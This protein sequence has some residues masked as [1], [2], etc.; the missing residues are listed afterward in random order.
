MFTGLQSGA[1]VAA[2]R[3]DGIGKPS[4][5]LRPTAKPAGDTAAISSLSASLG[6]SRSLAGSLFS[7]QSLFFLSHFGVRKSD[8]LSSFF[9]PSRNLCSAPRACFPDVFSCHVFCLSCF[10]CIRLSPSCVV[11]LMFHAVSLLSQTVFLPSKTK[12]VKLEVADLIFK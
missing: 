8:S 5:S 12:C 2:C 4:L 11:F 10:L 3:D 6:L 7:A 9:H 1:W